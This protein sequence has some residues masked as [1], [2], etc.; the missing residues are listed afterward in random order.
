[1]AFKPFLIIQLRPETEASD[2][3]FEAFL[4]FG[5]LNASDVVRIRA[6]KE[7]LPEINLEEYSGIIVGGSPF[8]IT[9]PQ[10]EKSDIQVKVESD[11]TKLFDKVVTQD[12]P[13]IGACSGNGL[14]GNYCG[15]TISKKYGEP[16]GGVD[17]TLTEA[18]EK[19]PI[20]AGLPNEFRALVGHKEACEM[21]PPNAV[22]L[23]SSQTCPTQMFRVGQ[24]VYATQFHPEAT[25]E[26]FILRINVY[27]YNGYFP[28]ED[29][30]RLINAVKDENI[31]EPS[32][33][34]KNFVEK[35]RNELK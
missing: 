28:P 12:F 2:N 7:G 21:T 18:G 31:T 20:L 25:S 32:K 13:F 26:T 5:E 11:F 29:A 10:N 30:E 16:V 23:A 9:T 24:N 6:E 1:M 8:D 35:Y 3:E 4:K 15:T 27:K 14:L 22:L 33:I 17:V 34:L 19:D